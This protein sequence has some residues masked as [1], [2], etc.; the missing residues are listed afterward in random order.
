MPT[1]NANTAT[2]PQPPSR[3]LF[4]AA[5]PAELSE[6]LPG[7]LPTTSTGLPRRQRGALD[8]EWGQSDGTSTEGSQGNEPSKEYQAALAHTNRTLPADTP[9]NNL[10]R[11]V[12][13][14]LQRYGPNPN[15]SRSADQGGPVVAVADTGGSDFTSLPA[16]QPAMREVARRRA[17]LVGA[18]FAGVREAQFAISRGGNPPAL[19]PFQHEAQGPVVTTAAPTQS[20]AQSEL[21]PDLPTD[22]AAPDDAPNSEDTDSFEDAVAAHALLTRLA[23]DMRSALAAPAN[24]VHALEDKNHSYAQTEPTTDG[25]Q[26]SGS[27]EPPQS[28]MQQPDLATLAQPH[29]GG[30]RNAAS[31]LPTIQARQVGV[32]VSADEFRLRIFPTRTTPFPN[33][34]KNDFVA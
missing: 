9:D 15:K 4:Q 17:A 14:G 19:P 7:G 11:R 3:D 28:T 6:S 22:F 10:L 18:A 13:I 16:P 29:P 27:E 12:L 8:H 21:G 32:P 24:A 30:W 2:S 34:P 26:L 23:S 1:E 33:T 31:I 5:T 20:P 25:P